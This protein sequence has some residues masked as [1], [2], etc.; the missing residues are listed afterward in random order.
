MLQHI[1]IY[2]T[3][4]WGKQ[5]SQR[6][7]LYVSRIWGAQSSQIQK[8]KMKNGGCQGLA[9]GWTGSVKWGQSF[10]FAGWRSS[11]DRWWRWLPTSVKVP[12]T[13]ERYLSKWLRWWVLWYVYHF[14][15]I[16]NTCGAQLVKHPTLDFGSGHDLVLGEF[17]PGVGLWADSA[18]PAWD[19]LYLP[20][21]LSAPPLLAL[22]LTQNK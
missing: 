16:E 7:I 8:D 21:S 19:S 2:R 5:V 11:V 15:T 4:W 1:C 17:E 22:S 13:T 12:N 3:L 20:L 14:V 18:K 9:G 6:Q 10:S